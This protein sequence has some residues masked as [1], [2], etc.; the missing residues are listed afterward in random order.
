MP[1]QKRPRGC[2]GGATACRSERGSRPRPRRAVHVDVGHTGADR[3]DELIELSGVEALGSRRCG[4]RDVGAHV[5]GDDGPD[6][7]RFLQQ[8]PRLRRCWKSQR[9]SVI[10]NNSCNGDRSCSRS[11]GGG[12]SVIRSGSCNGDQACFDAGVLGQSVIGNSPCNATGAC[13]RVGLGGSSA[14]G[15]SSCNDGF[16]ACGQAGELKISFIGIGSCKG[17]FACA[18]VGSNGDSIGNHSCNSGVPEVCEGGG[19][20]NNKN[21]APQTRRGNA[22]DVVGASNRPLPNGWGRRFWAVGHRRFARNRLS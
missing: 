12:N 9:H 20:G 18:F 14:I 21:N 1:T 3:I 22:T 7:P 2:H 4:R 17:F 11:G 8:Q 5:C 15:N 6:R 13:G 10:G 16:F 19:I